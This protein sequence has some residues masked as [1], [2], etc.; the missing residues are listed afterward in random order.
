MSAI[1]FTEGPV[2]VRY[3]MD[4]KTWAMVVE[5]GGSS[6]EVLEEHANDFIVE[7]PSRSEFESELH[8][9]DG[10]IPYQEVGGAT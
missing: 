6:C 3:P 10:M 8:R 2:R 5:G 1:S 9:F 4:P 7:Y